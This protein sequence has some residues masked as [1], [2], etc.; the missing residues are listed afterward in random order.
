MND[1]VM[2]FGIGFLTAAV[3]AYPIFRCLIALKSRQTV[4]QF[5]TEH[6]HKQGTPTMGGLII[7]AGGIPAL[8]YWASLVGTKAVASLA[9]VIGYALIGF[10]DD[11][12]LPRVK[13]GSRGLGWI[14]KLILQ[15]GIALAVVL[16]Q[17]FQGP[18]A[19]GLAVFIILFYSNAYNF[20][21]GLDWLAGT[22]FMGLGGTLF[23]LALRVGTPDWIY[24]IAG[25][26]GATIPFLFMNR[27]PAKVFMGDVGSMAIGGLMGLA[28]ADMTIHSI[29]LGGSTAWLLLGGI[30]LVSVIMFV[31][32]VP[33]PL[34][35]LSVKL[36]KR[37]I[38]P[39]TPIHHAFQRAGWTESRIVGL[40][41]AVQLI[42]SAAG[43][44]LIRMAGL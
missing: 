18:L 44:A 37:R 10:V 6:A 8:L 43:I 29:T 39:F 33:V 42:G 3:L 25:F 22:I 30:A 26:L 16:M 14:P 34:Q 23:V 13:K 27:P 28:V 19:V 41:F 21:D 4:S 5:V 20:S 15:I 36:F 35:I 2:V 9:I 17:G 32:L 7:L 24:P 1:L 40:F 38:F 12:V 31:E 11:F